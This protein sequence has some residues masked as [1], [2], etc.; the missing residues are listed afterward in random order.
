MKAIS[1]HQPWASLITLGENRFETR[2][3]HPKYHGP[4]LIH[5]SKTFNHVEQDL[6]HQHPFIETLNAHGIEF[7][8][9]LPTGAIIAV[10]TLADC[11]VV[12]ELVAKLSSNERA[13]GDFRSGRYAWLLRDIMCVSRG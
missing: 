10:A 2:S 1:I 13:F 11:H 4:I 9:Q 5:A 7:V 3:W 6:C 8:N 12:D